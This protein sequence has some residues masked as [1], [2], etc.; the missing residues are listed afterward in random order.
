MGRH[1]DPELNCS[2]CFLN[3]VCSWFLMTEFF[4]SHFTSRYMK[5]GTFSKH[6]QYSILNFYFLSC[7]CWQDENMY[8]IFKVQTSL[9]GVL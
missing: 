5:F 4:I 8:L 9:N 6:L 3:F 7:I 2:R 1:N